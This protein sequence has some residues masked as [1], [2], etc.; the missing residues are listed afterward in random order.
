MAGSMIT[1]LDGYTGKRRSSLFLEWNSIRAYRTESTDQ[2]NRRY[3]TSSIL[4][5]KAIGAGPTLLPFPG[6]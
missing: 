3:F 1:R 2:A 6:A 4:Y 5:V